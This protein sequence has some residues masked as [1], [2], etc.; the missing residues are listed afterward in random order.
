M[1]VILAVFGI[2]KT[3]YSQPTADFSTDVTACLAQSIRLQNLST[4]ASS[5]EWDFCANDILTLKSMDVPA[6]LTSLSAGYGFKL[7][8]DNGSW[9]GFAVSQGNN[10]IIRL[11]FGSTLT[12][13]PTIVNLGN[14]GGNLSLP[15]AL[16]IVK[17]GANWIGFATFL[18]ANSGFVRFDFGTSL[19]NTPTTT[20]VGT[21]GLTGSMWDLK[22]VSDLAGC[23]LICVNRGNN[24]IARISFGT[25]FLNSVSAGNVFE[26]IIPGAALLVGIDLIQIGTSWK[27]MVAD[28]VG[29]SIIQV[30]LGP[31]LASSVFTIEGNYTFPDFSNPLRVRLLQEGLSYRA[32]VANNS[33]QI[34][35]VDLKNT[36]P[37]NVPVEITHASIPKM[38]GISVARWAGKTILCGVSFYDQNVSRIIFEEDCN[39]S[40]LFATTQTP[41]GL[42]YSQTGN[43]V[44]ELKATDASGSSSIKALATTVSGLTSPDI[45]FVYVNNCAQN[46]IDFMSYNVSGGIASYAWNFGDSQT[47]NQINSTHSYTAAGNFLVDIT[48]TGSNGCMNFS[49]QTVDVF[50]PP[51]ANF[52]LPAASPVC[53]NQNYLLNSTSSF[54]AE[55]NPTYEWRLNGVLASTQ[56]NYTATFGI[57]SAQEVRLKILIPGCSNEVIKNI[58]SV[59]PG[60]SVSF[61]APD[62]CTGAIASFTNSTVGNDGTFQWNFGDSQTSTQPNPTYMYSSF[63]IKQVT[64]TAN[65]LNGCKNFV[66]KPIKVYSKPSPDFSVGL[67]PFACSNTAT[68]FQNNTPPLTDSNISTWSW[69]F[70][71]LAAGM[72]SQQNPSYVYSTG[73]N[74]NVALTALTDKGCSG[75]FTKN[76]S[77]A[78]S[79]VA[80]FTVGPSC[81]NLGTKFTDLSSGSVQTRAWQ[82]ASATF[83]IPSPTYTF[84]SPG[85]FLATLTVTGANL[86]ST[87]K[88]K[89]VNVPVPP[90]LDFVGSNLCSGKSTRF[91]DITLSPQDLIVGWNWNFAGN[92][93]TGNPV[94]NIFTTAGLQNIKMTTTHSSGCKYTLSK[95]VLI[96]TSPVADFIATPDR[97]S[98]PLIV[99]FT[100][101]S[102]LASN[103][104]W[105]FYD[106][107]LATTTQ[108]SPS[109]T[110]ISLGNYSTE[111]T[112][113]SAQGCVDVKVVPIIVLVPTV[114]LALTDFALTSDPTTGKLKGVITILNKSNIPLVSAEIGLILADK[115]VVNETFMINLNPGQSVSKT[116]SFTISPNQFEFNFLCA[117]IN[118][119]KD[120]DQSNNKRCINLEKVDYFFSPYPNPT[121]GLLHVDWISIV[122]EIAHLIIYDAMG[123][124]NYEWETLS[125][126]GLNQ[127]KLDVTFLSSGVY[128]LSIETSGV[129]K[130]SR[131]FRQ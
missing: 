129:K 62:V 111:L 8:Q 38:I 83:G 91:N 102:Q 58:A 41:S 26:S 19:S 36:N 10:S 52:Q 4:A 100:N 131:F 78:S 123:R 65:S 126:V 120:V 121:T 59:N 48:I 15:I 18:N 17:S 109:H 46:P 20:N 22:L 74:Y 34:S 94:E 44:I 89:T 64:L 3:C 80:D 105:K 99:Q 119:E 23:Y 104:V 33:G 92:S 103:Y 6:V 84:T 25:S 30:N 82:I 32:V 45:S 2:S 97:G 14:P 51:V 39:A 24:S 56:Q 125:A 98:A 110:F 21:F 53:T 88:T 11:D 37:I 101:T 27:A 1:L 79:P 113:T 67:P 118:S 31:L 72:S 35:L 5:Y 40:V 28:Y 130:T 95:N 70:G 13:T 115:A 57:L 7:L 127:S 76:I 42:S 128:F 54:D 12:G 81:L 68:P 86:C 66:T 122:P 55:S 47:D 75:T 85:D 108:T 116:L 112:A 106:R 61:T 16:D 114:D 69:Q 43:K 60:P 29:N 96:N 90:A 71:D 87:F 124:K 9:Y 49:T 50:T 77:I 73:A 93:T 107:V 117:Q 63:G